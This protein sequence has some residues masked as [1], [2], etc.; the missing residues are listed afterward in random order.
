[1]TGSSRMRKPAASCAATCHVH[2]YIR[3]RFR[4]RSADGEAGGWER[5]EHV[6]VMEH[7]LGR[8]LEPWE[9]VHHKNGIRADNRLENLELLHH[10]THPAGRATTDLHSADRGSSRRTSRAPCRERDHWRGVALSR[11][12]ALTSVAA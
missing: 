5:M 8:A 6:V 2:G 1:M 11:A 3:L 4:Y 7:H 9:R 12:R 10:S